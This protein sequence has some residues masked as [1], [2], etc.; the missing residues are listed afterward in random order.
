[1][2]GRHRKITL[3]FLIV[4][5][6]KF[7]PDTCFGLIK[8]VYR[9]TFVGCL[10]DISAVVAKS[11]V[12]NESQLVGTQ[13]G[14]TVVPVYDWG[15]FFDNTTKKVKGI[16]KFQHFRF[17]HE[18]P[19]K[20]FARSTCDGDE[21]EFSLVRDNSNQTLIREFPNGIPPPGLSAER[22]QYLYEKI[23]EFCPE[24]VRTLIMSKNFIVLTYLRSRMK[25]V[26]GQPCLVQCTRMK[27]KR[28]K[29]MLF[30]QREE[31]EDMAAAP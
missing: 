22:R 20:V 19:G 14:S 21:K 3:S 7:S 5:H 4:G 16:K 28:M 12:V 31:N 24:E 2:T 13:D 18:H 8:Q 29:M 1:M 25:Y 6:T 27:E 30:P 9:R 15:G 23:R 17:T 11:S 26:L 10:D